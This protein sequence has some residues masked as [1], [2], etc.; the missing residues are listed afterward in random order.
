[1]TQ[2]PYAFGLF[3]AYNLF[4]LYS[5]APAFSLGEINNAGANALILHTELEYLGAI[6]QPLQLKALPLA[7]LSF[8]RNSLRK[9]LKGS[10]FY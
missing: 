1:M 5:V 2:A 10:A 7:H 9:L 6:I 3:P 4:D 8:M